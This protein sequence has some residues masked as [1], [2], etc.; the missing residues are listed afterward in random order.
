MRNE[1]KNFHRLNNR[2]LFVSNQN[3]QK[4]NKSN[5]PNLKQDF[6]NSVAHWQCKKKVDKLVRT[7]QNKI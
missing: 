2:N 3:K 5:N 4:E 6:K 7:L 1:I